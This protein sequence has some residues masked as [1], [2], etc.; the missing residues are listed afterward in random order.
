MFRIFLFFVKLA[1]VAILAAMIGLPIY[2]WIAP[3]PFAS[4]VH[5]RQLRICVAIDGEDKYRG[6]QLSAESFRQ[7]T[8]AFVPDVFRDL[9]LVAVTHFPTTGQIRT[10]RYPWSLIYVIVFL[11]MCSWA[12]WRLW[13]RPIRTMGWEKFRRTV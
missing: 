5:S 7:R 4:E 10:E 6:N 2:D 9:G 3:A 13:I 8:Y 1:P 12:T 11:A